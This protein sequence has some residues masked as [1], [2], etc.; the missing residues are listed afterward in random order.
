M[1][2]RPRKKPPCLS[3][4]AGALSEMGSGVLPWDLHR[5]E[6]PIPVL[7]P[8]F[9]KERLPYVSQVDGPHFPL[10]LSLPLSPGPQRSH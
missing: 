3:L 7:L 10:V 4:V 6:R 8:S 1:G 9:S 5:W 2:R